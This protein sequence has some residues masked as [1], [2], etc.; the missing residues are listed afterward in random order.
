[1]QVDAVLKKVGCRTEKKGGGF[2][3]EVS[4]VCGWGY[5]V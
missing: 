2:G 3:A 5:G 1:M 4:V